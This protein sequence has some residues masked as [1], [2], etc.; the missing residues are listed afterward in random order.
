MPLSRDDRR[1]T[2]RIESAAGSTVLQSMAIVAAEP[3][4]ADAYTLDPLGESYLQNL[5]TISQGA[6]RYFLDGTEPT[7][8]LHTGESAVFHFNFT[9]EALGFQY[10]YTQAGAEL[11]AEISA[12]GAAWHPSSPAAESRKQWSCRA[13]GRSTSGSLRR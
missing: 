11:K 10:A 1:F 13:A 8:F 2:L 7:V 6:S 3:E 4:L 9:D 12:D 5:Y